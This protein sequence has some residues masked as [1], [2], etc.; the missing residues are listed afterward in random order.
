[1]IWSHLLV[2]FA[3]IVNLFYFWVNADRARKNAGWSRLLDE[4][5]AMLEDARRVLSG[6]IALDEEEIRP[7]LDS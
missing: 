2:T 4:R 1:M 6:A 7:G 5:Q 3:A